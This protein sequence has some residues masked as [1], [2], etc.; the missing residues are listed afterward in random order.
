M[1]SWDEGGILTTMVGFRVVGGK[2]T[3]MRYPC[4][5]ANGMKRDKMAL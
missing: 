5:M 3:M 1:G 2:W 4:S